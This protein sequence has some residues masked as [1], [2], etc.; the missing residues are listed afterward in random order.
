M[1]NPVFRNISAPRLPKLLAAILPLP[2]GEGWGEGGF[3]RE[4]GKR[5]PSHHLGAYFAAAAAGG[6]GV[7]LMNLFAHAMKYFMLD[8][9]S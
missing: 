7:C 4:C 1:T 3:A 5:I 9:S 8:R 2:T 6:G